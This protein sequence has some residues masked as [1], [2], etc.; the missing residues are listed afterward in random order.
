MQRKPTITSLD[1][2]IRQAMPG[3]KRTLL[4]LERTKLI[5]KLS[6]EASK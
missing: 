6:K 3:R 5:I 2:Q 1:Q 4:R